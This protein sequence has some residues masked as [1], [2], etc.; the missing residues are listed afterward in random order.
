[1]KNRFRVKLLIS[2]KPI[3]R[4]A[5]TLRF[6]LLGSAFVASYLK[7]KGIYVE[8]DDLDV[9][10]PYL[11]AFM[12]S[13]L[14]RM[15]GPTGRIRMEDCLGDRHFNHIIE[16][17]LQD[18]VYT[19]FNLIGLSVPEGMPN[20]TIA[21]GL[22]KRIKEETN[23]PIVLGG[24]GLPDGTT[25]LEN[26][27]WIDYVILHRG[28]KSLFELCK[29]LESRTSVED[30]IAGLVYRKN[31]QV[32]INKPVFCYGISHLVPDFEG[33]PLSSYGYDL[34]T[35]VHSISTDPIDED[36][37]QRDG[38]KISIFPHQFIEG[39]AKRCAF[40][41]N[42]IAKCKVTRPDNVALG[43]AQLSREYGA[44]YF[45]FLNSEINYSYKYAESL[46]H[47]IINRDL[48]IMWSDSAGLTNLDEKL[49]A[50]M[51]RA[52][53]VRLWYGVEVA[54]D[55]ML[56]FVGKTLTVKQAETGLRITHQAGIWNGVNLI[57]GMPYETEDDIKRTA[58][59]IQ[60]NR[61]YIDI[62]TLN[63]FELRPGSRFVE[64]PE[65]YGIRFV[66]QGMGFE[67]IDGLNWK[68]KEEQ[69][70]K[71]YDTL[72]G[73]ID[74]KYNMVAWNTHLI[75]YLYSTMGSKKEIRKWIGSASEK[76][77]HSAESR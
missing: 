56:K 52:G 67:E 30:K 40:C 20:F 33:L 8:Q 28:E 37:S 47:E 68:E 64:Y 38:R 32:Y 76:I 10:S 23:T 6:P 13:F 21:V 9:K 36:V 48:D 27:D 12:E 29:M 14:K 61:E 50:K 51:R 35:I 11:K 22:A 54:S 24:R 3:V 62:Y 60:R 63:K 31:H 39:C 74:A 75:F 55:R 15:S 43:L 72:S 46:C 7:K 19:G 42:S 49:A 66:P 58:E 44:Q 41:S 5:E 17:I 45:F 59:F 53:C 34:G 57:V 70:Q 73:I 26:F 71:A 1:M 65:K 18:T 77:K 4:K 25:V 16:K 69:T 2:P